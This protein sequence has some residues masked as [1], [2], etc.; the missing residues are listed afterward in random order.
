MARLVELKTMPPT[1]PPRMVLV[2]EMV[3][4]QV[5]VQVQVLEP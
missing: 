2:L 1:S 3:M 4:V 5:L